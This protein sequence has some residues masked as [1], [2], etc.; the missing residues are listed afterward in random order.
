MN[1]PKFQS[2]P[3]MLRGWLTASSAALLLGLSMGAAHANE[4]ATTI[5]AACH[6][7]DGDTPIAPN[8]PRIAGLQKEYI[9]KQLNDFLSGKRKSD[10]MLPMAQQI[11]P[12]QI[13]TVA[14]YFSQQKRSHGKAESRVV[15]SAGKVM[16]NAGNE[17]SGVPACVGCHQPKGAGFLSSTG[18]Y[19]RLSGQQAEYVKEQLKAFATGERSNDQSRFM[20]TTAKRMTDE[21]I[22]EVAQ[23]LMG[24]DD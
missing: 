23:Y 6:G 4:I 9:V 18:I 10:V 12:D 20:R 17:E 14:E 8:Y 19:P 21:E 2:R 3:A 7:A 15:A 22:D 16:Y 5:C 24:V 11:P 13:E 1:N